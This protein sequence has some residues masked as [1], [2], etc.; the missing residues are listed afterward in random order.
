MRGWWHD[1]ANR[2]ARL[3]Q[4]R[5]HEEAALPPEARLAYEREQTVLR[6]AAAQEQKARLAHAL[7]HGLKV[8]IDCSFVQQHSCSSS[9]SSSYY[10]AGLSPP[11]ATRCAA[12]PSS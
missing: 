7:S 3:Q 6:I 12:W 2:R 4:L 5:E 8:V 10:A 1:R 11:P 9:G